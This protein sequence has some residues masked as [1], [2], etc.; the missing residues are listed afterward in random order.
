MQNW[1]KFAKY[2][3]LFLGFYADQSAFPVMS[4][5][6]SEKIFLSSLVLSGSNKPDVW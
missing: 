4:W 6:K 3:R 5:T 1:W 2:G